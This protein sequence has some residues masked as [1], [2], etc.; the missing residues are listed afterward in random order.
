MLPYLTGIH[1]NWHVG[2]TG[3]PGINN[4]MQPEE[5]SHREMH[6]ICAPKVNHRK[7]LEESAPRI[8][9]IYGHRHRGVTRH[10]PTVPP[11]LLERAQRYLEDGVHGTAARTHIL[12]DRLH[13]EDFYWVYVNRTASATT[14]VTAAGVKTF[15]DLLNQGKTKHRSL[16][17]FA[18]VAQGLHEVVIPKDRASSLHDRDGD[19]CTCAHF[20]SWRVCEHLLAVRACLFPE[21]DDIPLMLG[22]SHRAK[23]GR[24][25]LLKN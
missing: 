13:D 8:L 18:K 2:S 16:K 25:F 17:A 1:S 15:T 24:Q 9:H 3:V 22:P 7:W 14:P 10:L 21:T 23:G 20:W 5:R 19:S 6:R 12:F 11:L 4:S